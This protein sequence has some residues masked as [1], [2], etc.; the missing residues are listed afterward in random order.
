MDEKVYKKLKTY[1]TISIFSSLIAVSLLVYIIISPGGQSNDEFR[2]M[3]NGDFQ[4][5][6]GGRQGP[7]FMD[8]SNLIDEDTG[9]VDYDAVDEMKESS[10]MGTDDERFVSMLE[11]M[12][13]QAVE[14]GEITQSQANEIYY[15]FTK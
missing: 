3:V 10:P 2:P 12:L 7:G 4:G 14:E 13:D 11:R 5:S 15:Q 9:E 1:K 6:F 8:I